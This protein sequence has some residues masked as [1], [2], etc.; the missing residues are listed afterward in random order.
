MERSCIKA[1]KALYSLYASLNIYNN[2][3]NVPLF[4]KLFKIIIKP[5]L[6]YGSEVWGYHCVKTGT[7]ISKFINRFYK[8]LLGVPNHTS[9]T[10][11]HLDLNCTPIETEIK[12]NLI[13]Y[14]IPISQ[15]PSNR[16]VSQ[17]YKKLIANGAK[18]HFT[19]A[20]QTII[21]SVGLQDI[22]ENQSAIPVSDKTYM[23]SIL[24]V[25]ENSIH[26][27]CKTTLIENAQ[28]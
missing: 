7:P 4:I 23:K 28:K 14:W 20:I 1:R 2:E 8:T 27:Q 13:K 9:N 3:G 25:F 16:L 26:S 21:S 15:L 6:T 12:L 5:I 22:W 10:A 17:S 11:I 19:L 18:D 24:T